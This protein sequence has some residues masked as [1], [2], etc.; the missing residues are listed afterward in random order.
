M[1][2][3]FNLIA[4]SLITF[5]FPL[6]TELIT[7]KEKEKFR[8]LK[9][10]LYS[11]F[12]CF[13]LFISGF[14]LLFGKEI[15]VL[16]FS[17]AYTMSGTLIQIVAPCFIFNSRFTIS[18]SILA[19]LGLIKKR[20]WIIF[21]S[22]ILNLLLNYFIIIRG[23]K[24]VE[25]SGIIMGITR[26]IMGLLGFFTVQKNDQFPIKR[27]FLLKNFITIGI[28]VLGFSQLKVFFPF[29]ES[30]TKDRILI[31]CI[32]LLYTL[33]CILVNGRECKDLRNKVKHLKQKK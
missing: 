24:G 9:T 33:P 11:Y 22:L 10:I 23:G 12:G 27:G 4:N 13:A 17:P 18:F 16:L 2:G 32:T 7:R 25:R 8:S 19:G 3:I 29:G 5:I 30:N 21:T 1:L 26:I 6:T 14:F 15:A 31:L 28:L 20:F